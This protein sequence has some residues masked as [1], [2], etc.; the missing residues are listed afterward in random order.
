MLKLT[1][2]NTQTVLVSPAN[3]ASMS[4]RCDGWYRANCSIMQHGSAVQQQFTVT[5]KSRP[6]TQ[7]KWGVMHRVRVA[8]VRCAAACR[9]CSNLQVENGC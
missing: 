4:D 3:A 9:W 7:C 8:V 2:Q 5:G 1:L 6:E